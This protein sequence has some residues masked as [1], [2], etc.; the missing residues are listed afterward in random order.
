M[1]VVTGPEYRRQDG[2]IKTVGLLAIMAQSRLARAGRRGLRVPGLRRRA[3]RHRRRAE[4]GA[5]AL[6]VLVA[7]R[8]G[9][10]RSWARRRRESL[11]L[12]D[13]MGAG[14]DPPTV[15]PWAG[16]SSTSSAASAAGRS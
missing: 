6:D 7:R 1:L 10:A 3:G 11:V 14:T 13:E 5:V 16:R 2:G 12:L 8:G 4:P 9:S 15:P